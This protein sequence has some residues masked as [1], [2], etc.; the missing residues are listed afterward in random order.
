MI[1]SRNSLNEK[2]MKRL[3]EL[4]HSR[5][6]FYT[7]IASHILIWCKKK[8][9]TVNNSIIDCFQFLAEHFAATIYWK[10]TTTSPQVFGIC[11][12]QQVI[13]SSLLSHLQAHTVS[14]CFSQPFIE[15]SW[16]SHRKLQTFTQQVIS[17]HFLQQVIES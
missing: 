17:F 5:E 9:P 11:I 15:S 13:E 3:Q 10:F 12:L 6:N 14:I 7:K 8:C 4:A 16:E 1:W 2:Q